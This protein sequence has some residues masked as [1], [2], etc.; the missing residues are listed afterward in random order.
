MRKRTVSIYIR[1]TGEEKKRILRNAT[2]CRL[3][4]SEYLRQLANGHQP[5][6]VPGF[7]LE[8]EAPA[9]AD[10]TQAAKPELYPHWP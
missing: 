5:A 9:N 2:M 7:A 8:E 1:V 3:P 6:G 10:T 4:V